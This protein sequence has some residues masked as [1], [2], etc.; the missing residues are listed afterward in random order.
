MGPKSAIAIVQANLSEIYT[1]LVDGGKIL[2]LRAVKEQAIY[3]SRSWIALL[4]RFINGEQKPEKSLAAVSYS[5]NTLFNRAVVDEGYAAYQQRALNW[6]KL[7][8]KSHA[9]GNDVQQ[10][11]TDQ[12]RKFHDYTRL[13]FGVT[14]ANPNLPESVEAFCQNFSQKMGEEVISDKRVGEL[15]ECVTRCSQ[16]VRPF[17]ELFIKPG[18]KLIDPIR[19]LAEKQ[20]ALLNTSLHRT[21]NKA[22][23]LIDLEGILELDIPF[24]ALAKISHTDLSLAE[25]LQIRQWIDRLNEKKSEIDFNTFAEVLAEIVHLINIEGHYPTTIEKFIQALDKMGCAI[26]QRED[27]QHMQ[28]RESLKTGSTIDHQGKILTLGQEIGDKL[29]DNQFRIF[30]LCGEEHKGHIIKIARNRFQLVLEAAKMQD[31]QSHW[32]IQPARMV[33]DINEASVAKRVPVP[34]LDPQGRF[35]IMEKLGPSLA[36]TIWTSHSHQITESDFKKAL[37]LSNHLYCMQQWEAIPDHLNPQHLMFDSGEVFKSSRPLKKSPFNYN[38]LE[39]FVYHLR[40]PSVVHFIMQVSQLVKHKV[41]LFYR[42]A[43]EF[44]LKTG[45]THLLGLEQPKKFRSTQNEERVTDL[46]K[47]A[48]ELRVECFKVIQAH[49]RRNGNNKYESE[50]K[51]QAEVDAKLVELYKASSTPG[52]LSPSIKDGVLQFFINPPPVQVIPADLTPYY[53]AA[54][55]R[56]KQYNDASK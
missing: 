5:M 51:L 2:P 21:F 1:A 26:I 9:P 25:K 49:F 4:D 18:N 35:V 50:E 7:L 44:T 37:A 34:G 42:E 52:I 40:N 22:Q 33:E 36:D 6:I 45:Q 11:A 31:E 10:L 54:F 56:M 14:Q 30:A 53:E 39:Q 46:C 48:K 38:V 27:A 13:A 3:H 28:W 43:V 8:S 17:W 20:G 41:A 12:K 23:N 19:E 15:R 47:Q 32:G 24:V 29:V 16:A 55:Q